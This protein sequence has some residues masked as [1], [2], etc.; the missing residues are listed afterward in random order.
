M[1]VLLTYT[2][3][4]RRQYY[5]DRALAALQDV[6]DVRLHEADLPLGP[7]E[8]VAASHG[9]DVIV[10][11]RLTPAPAEVFQKLSGLKAFCRGAVDIRNIDVAAA[12]AAGILVTRAR[13][14]FMTSVAELALG[15]M[16]DL[17]RGISRAAAD[18]HAGRMPEVRVGRE[19]AGATA[20]IVGYGAIAC[21]LAPMLAH[22]GMN[23]LISDPYVQV[24]DTRF[25]QVSFTDLLAR[26]HYVICLAVATEETENLFDAA[27]FARMRPDSC[28]VNL[29]R[30]NLVDED[31]LVHALL[32]QRIAGAAI[33]VG[34]AVDQM[35]SPEVAALPNVIATP[36]IAGL[37]PEAA[38]AQAFDTVRQVQALL[39]GEIPEGAVNVDA[40]SRRPRG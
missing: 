8:L 28:F 9:I 2:P 23:V 18:Y 25:E 3:Q 27:A 22:L 13:P 24:D 17:A 36:H 40:W 34:R 39:R 15:F 38:G 26:S 21:R 29:S 20:G 37:T 14:G 12:S 19:L 5:G 7:A 16:I 30:G 11:D 32:Q 35:P 33:D 10:A 6:A 4:A 1:K 31:A